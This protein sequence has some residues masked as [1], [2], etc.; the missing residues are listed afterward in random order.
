MVSHQ[1]GSERAVS[2]NSNNSPESSKYTKH[3]RC[4][5]KH[6]AADKAF[7]CRKLEDLLKE[8]I[9]LL[10]VWTHGMFKKMQPRFLPIP[11]I[12]SF[13]SFALSLSFLPLCLSPLLRT[14][15]SL[16]F[17]PD[18]CVLQECL[19]ALSAL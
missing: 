18:I 9:M 3:Y 4:R 19:C 16:T 12:N 15:V 8:S 7:V 11:S 1:P 6:K 13:P 2:N 5:W 14:G 17:D 10:W